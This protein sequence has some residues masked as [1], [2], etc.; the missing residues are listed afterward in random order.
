[1]LFTTQIPPPRSAAS[2]AT[3]EPPNIQAISG[4]KLRTAAEGFIMSAS[5]VDVSQTKG[6]LREGWG[7]EEGVEGSQIHQ[8]QW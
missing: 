1:M 5:A 7:E 3:F 4:Q 8:R 6:R 2:Q